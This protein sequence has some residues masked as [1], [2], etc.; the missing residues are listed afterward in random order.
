M[1]HRSMLKDLICICISV[2][3]VDS[4]KMIGYNLVVSLMV[5]LKFYMSHNMTMAMASLTDTEIPVEARKYLLPHCNMSVT[6]FLKFSLPMLQLSTTF[7]TSNQYLSPSEPNAMDIEDIRQLRTPPAPI[8]ES[9][10][11]AMDP[12][13]HQSVHCPHM[14]TTDGK[15]YPLWVIQ[16]W[17]ELIPIRTIHQKWVNADESLQKQN[18][19]RKGVSASDPTLICKVYN[20]LSCVSWTG[21]IQG[22][23][24]A[25]PTHYLADYATKEW[26]TDEHITQM[27]DLLQQDVI[28]EGLSEIIKI[29]PV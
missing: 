28:R 21:N 7:T 10:V 11:K 14:G 17:A 18:E 8:I 13:I 26:M 4:H 19:S 15:K 9:L 23:S 3:V 16:Y 6:E 20:A 22:F 27:L 2:L 1:N 24:I 29:E 12:S 5:N 25:I